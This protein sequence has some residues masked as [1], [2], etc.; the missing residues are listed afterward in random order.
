MA[1]YGWNFSNTPI[2]KD[3]KKRFA[4]KVRLGRRPGPLWWAHLQGVCNTD[5]ERDMM[6]VQAQTETRKFYITPL[7]VVN[8]E[9]WM[10]FY[11]Y[12]QYQP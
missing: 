8:G 4:D 3:V 1:I 9:E 2:P 6:L 12:H 7:R 11:V 5:K 10:G